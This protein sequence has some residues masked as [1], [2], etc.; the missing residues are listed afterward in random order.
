MS[1]FLLCYVVIQLIILFGVFIL[2]G[3]N[4]KIGNSLFSSEQLIPDI[5]VLRPIYTLS[6]VLYL[7][8]IALS[9]VLSQKWFKKIDLD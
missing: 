8:I 6:I 9:F 7:I 2:A 5:S 1:G 3:I 4:P